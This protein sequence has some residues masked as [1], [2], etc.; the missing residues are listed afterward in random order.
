M[1]ESCVLP[2]SK[3]LEEILGFTPEF[4]TYL[5]GLVSGKQ[6]ESKC[7]KE[8]GISGTKVVISLT[9]C[10]PGK[11]DDHDKLSRHHKNGGNPGNQPE[12]HKRNKASTKPVFRKKKTPS[13][14]RRDQKRFRMFL[15]RKKQERARKAVSRVVPDTSSTTQVYP[16][17][18][19]TASTTATPLQCPPPPDFSVTLGSPQSGL[20]VESTDSVHSDSFTEEQCLDPEIPTEYPVESPAVPQSICGCGYCSPTIEELVNLDVTNLFHACSY[21]QLLASEATNGLKTCSKCLSAAYCSKT[22]QSKDWKDGAHKSI[23]SEEKAVL[24]RQFRQSTLERKERAIEIL[25]LYNCRLI[26]NLGQKQ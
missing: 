14:R 24:V 4:T 21:C 20:S 18:T 9:F 2:G 7:I 8:N 6:L 26:Q 16:P 25:R 22:C 17:D 5:S 12:N 15:D 11:H 23:C 1:M 3:N 19:V 13:R 10:V